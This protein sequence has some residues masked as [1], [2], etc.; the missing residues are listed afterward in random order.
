[1]SNFTI[2]IQQ[3]YNFNVEVIVSL[4]EEDDN[5]DNQESQDIQDIDK[6]SSEKNEKNI[7]SLLFKAHVH[8]PP[9]SFWDNRREFTADNLEEL[10][11]EVTQALNASVRL[12]LEV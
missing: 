1:M 11:F 5:Q 2:R 4:I 12:Q 10:L 6:I 3:H 7:P 8:Q 9:A